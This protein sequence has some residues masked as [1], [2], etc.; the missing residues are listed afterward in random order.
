M[1]NPAMHFPGRP[2]GDRPCCSD[3]FQ[4]N[5]GAPGAFFLRAG[6]NEAFSPKAASFGAF[7]LQGSD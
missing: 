6:L 5:A 7:Q 1:T 2:A 4:V 3:A